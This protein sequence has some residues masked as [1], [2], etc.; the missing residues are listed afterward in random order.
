MDMGK[1]NLEHENGIFIEGC[2]IARD[3]PTKPTL[4]ASLAT[5]VDSKVSD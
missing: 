2:G 3:D 1:D 4:G 5:P